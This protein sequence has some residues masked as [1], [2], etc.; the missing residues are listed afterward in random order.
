MN[1]DSLN[2]A[3]AGGSI[4]HYNLDMHRNRLT[5]HVG[6]L[7]NGVYSAHELQF[8]KVSRLE[9]ETESKSDAGERLELT[10]LWIDASPE[11]SQQDGTGM[12][13]S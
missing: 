9:F 2:H 11:G 12:L 7:E 5:M 13:C 3:L 8:E 10:E 4:E 1:R 6:V